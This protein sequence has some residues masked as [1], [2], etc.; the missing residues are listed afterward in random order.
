MQKRIPGHLDHLKERAKRALD[1]EYAKR[2][3]AEEKREKEE[4]QR[5]EKERIRKEGEVKALFDEIKVYGKN[6]YVARIQQL[7]EFLKLEKNAVTFWEN[8][9]IRKLYD[10][11]NQINFL[12][13]IYTEELYDETAERDL[14]NNFAN[15]FYDDNF[16]VFYDRIS[17]INHRLRYEIDSVANTILELHQRTNGY[18]SKT[19]LYEDRYDTSFLWHSK[20]DKYIKSVKYADLLDKNVTVSRLAS[21]ENELFY[22]INPLFFSENNYLRLDA[23]A[24]WRNVDSLSNEWDRIE[25]KAPAMIKLL[26]ELVRTR[27]IYL[28]E[29]KK[30]ERRSNPFAT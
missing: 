20:R 17:R 29:I 4:L 9:H 30:R 13:S 10:V 2:K 12:C 27:K 28:K 22:I 26:D 5:K 25:R 1:P 16:I 18:I 7:L 21:A 19:R 15:P 11:S 23:Y 6:R 14:H 8:P 24:V 3:E